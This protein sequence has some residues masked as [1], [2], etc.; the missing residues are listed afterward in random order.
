MINA[1]M[2]GLFSGFPS[3]QFP[4]DI[5]ERLKKELVI[6]AHLVF[7]SA[8]PSDYERNNRDAAGMHAYVRAVR[9]AFYRI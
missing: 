5:A 3:R 4:A 8:W 1:K 2:L 7:I 9:H 6:R